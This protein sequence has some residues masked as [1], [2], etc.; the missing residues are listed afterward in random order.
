MLC[1]KC[2]SKLVVSEDAVLRYLYERVVEMQ[3]AAYVQYRA[4]WFA[5]FQGHLFAMEKLHATVR[6]HLLVVCGCKTALSS[7]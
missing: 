6:T 3:D 4:G 5:R 7:L 1:R 2:F